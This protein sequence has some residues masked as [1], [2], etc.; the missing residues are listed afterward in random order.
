M[1]FKGKFFEKVISTILRSI[2]KVI[3]NDLFWLFF[4]NL[5][6]ITFLQFTK[7]PLL[8]IFYRLF[9]NIVHNPLLELSSL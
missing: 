3:F 8:L 1:I 2:S 9:L 5:P 7:W 4:L 6:A